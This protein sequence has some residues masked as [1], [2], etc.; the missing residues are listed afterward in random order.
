[1]KKVFLFLI[2][3]FVLGH[4]QAQFTLGRTSDR[5]DRKAQKRKK[6]NALIRQAEEGTLVYT[7]QSVFGFQARSNGYGFLYELGKMKTPLKSNIYRVELT[8]IKH[9][10]E[11]KF[12]NLSNPFLFIS[13][14]YIYG[15]VNNFYQLSLG[16][17]QQRLLGQKGN[18]NGV[19]VSWNYLGGLSAGFLK[20]YYV[21]VE[22]STGTGVRHIKYTSKDSA[23]FLGPAILGAGGF[24]RG[25]NELKVKP[26]FFTKTSLRYDYGRFNEV[27]SALEIGCS[28]EYYPGNNPIMALQPEKSLFFQAYIAILF[29]RRK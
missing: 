13:N 4:A 29:G 3:S 18:K 9:P 2:F 20:P 26:G 23:L 6:I 17:G 11:N 24:W 22:D 7:K 25:W 1:M 27:V 10:K 12:Q 15:K 16:V 28:V 14:P 21:Q 8:E 5:E 19:S